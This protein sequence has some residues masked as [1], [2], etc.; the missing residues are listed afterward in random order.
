MATGKI[1][2]IG[3]VNIGIVGLDE[4]ISQI[5]ASDPTGRKTSDEAAIEV[6]HIIEKK[7]YIPLSARDAY[8]EAIKK[9]WNGTID[10][11]ESGLSIRI[12]GPGCVSCNRLEEIVRSAL[13]Q[14]DIAADIEH[15]KDLDE[16]WRYGVISTPALVING[17]VL[18][19]GRL[20]T[21]AKVEEWLREA[22]LRSM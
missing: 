13:D 5:R 18:C 8:I 1:I 22:L 16:I 19:S 20:P 6:L 3:G 11:N 10:G 2:N 4:A 17:Q 9:L 14:K 21:K 7:N 12:L 15:I